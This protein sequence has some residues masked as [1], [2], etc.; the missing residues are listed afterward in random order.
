MAYTRHQSFYLR[1]KWI[2]K[3]LKGVLK[4]PRFFFKDDSPEQIGLG[5]NMVQSLRF[6]MLATDLIYED[7]SKK[8]TEHILTPF[9]RIIY[10]NDRLLQN[11]NTV[12]LLHYHL[13]RNKENLATVFDWYFN[14]FKEMITQRDTLLKIFSTWVKNNDKY[15]SPTSLK[16]DI[17]CLIQLYTKLPEQNDPEDFIFSPFTK[18][19]LLKQES[20]KGTT[21]NI[22]KITPGINNIGLIAFYYVLL[23]YG[24]ENE[25]NLVS[26]EEI[27][28]EDYLWGKVFNLTRNKTI[29]T[30]NVLSNHKRYPL[31]YVRTNNLD[32]VRLPC[33]SS[34]EYLLNEYGISLDRVEDYYGN[35]N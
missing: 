23:K 2:S 1:S 28:N 4:D 9:G 20:T 6:W 15:V 10:K 17:D 12:S 19:N 3:G 18:L 33:I 24:E 21:E 30:L 35:K 34:E 13:I 7:K 26:V 14:E 32:N 31:E 29:E 25:V 11:N 22:R 16:K 8:H 5:K 27:L